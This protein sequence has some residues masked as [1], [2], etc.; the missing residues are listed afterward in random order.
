VIDQ[1]IVEHDWNKSE[2][3]TR[4][5]KHGLKNP[6]K[7]RK[8]KSKHRIQSSKEILTAANQVGEIRNEFKLEL[9]D[10]K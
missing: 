9:A 3:I 2:A 6:T 10:L 4:G 7:S 8:Q 1:F 5:D